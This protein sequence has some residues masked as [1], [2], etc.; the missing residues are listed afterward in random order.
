VTVLASRPWSADSAF[1]KIEARGAK[2]DFLVGTRAGRQKQRGSQDS[3]TA[4][5][6]RHRT[7]SVTIEPNGMRRE[8]GSQN[9]EGRDTAPQLDGLSR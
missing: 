2:Y 3:A 9:A 7:F 6:K 1:L 8:G 4:N 5:P